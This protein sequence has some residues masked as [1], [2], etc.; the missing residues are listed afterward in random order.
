V[1]RSTFCPFRSNFGGLKG[2]RLY[3]TLKPESGNRGQQIPVSRNAVPRNIWPAG[4]QIP[5]GFADVAETTDQ[6]RC[7]SQGVL[8]EVGGD[9]AEAAA[10]PPRQRQ[11]RPTAPT[12]DDSGAGRGRAHPDRP[13]PAHL[14]LAHLPLAHLPTCHLPTCILHLASCILLL[15]SCILHLASC[16]L[17]SCI[18]C[19]NTGSLPSAPLAGEKI[20]VWR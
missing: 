14:P 17:H 16:F 7:D 4:R 3:D 11:R 20:P 2:Q 10:S 5:G 19:Y 6:R 1:F 18:L 9:A 15:A 8:E 12:P 13:S